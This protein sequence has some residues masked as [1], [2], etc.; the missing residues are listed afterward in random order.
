MLMERIIL[1]TGGTG[2]HIFPALAVAEEIYRR[3]PNAMILFMGSRHGQEA[4]MAA[5]AGLD[6][7]GLPVRGI[8][9]RGGRGML[10]ALGMLR[11]LAKA[12]RVIRTIR[13]QVVVGFGGYASFAGVLA[14]RIAG[15]T[16]AIHEQNCYPGMTNR[17]LGKV[18]D[19]VFLSMPDT[20]GVFDKSK[21]VLVGN[22]VRAAIA[23]LHEKR[24]RERKGE[25]PVQRKEY[26]EGDATQG[27][28][29]HTKSCYGGVFAPGP[30]DAAAHGNR[31][32][33]LKNVTREAQDEVAGN[34]LP[35]GFTGETVAKEDHGNHNPRLLVMGGS[36]GARAINHAM[37]RAI[38]A[39]L[40]A[41]IDIWH[42]TGQADYDSVRAAY[43][44]AG[45]EN[46]RVEAFIADMQRAYAWADMVLCRAGGSSMAEITAAGLPAILVPLPWAAQD[47]QRANARFLEQ[48]GGAVVLE[49]SRFYSEREQAPAL[50]SARG[51][52]G[53]GI[54][55]RT[56]LSLLHDRPALETMA[57]KSLAAAKPYAA[58][59]LV[60]DLQS[61]LAR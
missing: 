11:G 14:A 30:F 50:R 48:E 38:E 43:R 32:N 53:T 46:I 52:D 36:L 42:Q 23:E 35:E 58:R 12:Y 8:L 24:L 2:G 22:P 31:G 10:A 25:M 28:S 44:E 33:L 21:T 13:P 56:I 40:E 45:A 7:V 1:T 47:H 6:F 54:F 16:T 19:R 3:N 37:M 9:G 5:K 18:V 57:R 26:K 29:R 51:E 15:M 27:C 17:L 60:D 59:N 4:D 49:Q 41:G 61:L 20:A 34:K 55:I 39:L